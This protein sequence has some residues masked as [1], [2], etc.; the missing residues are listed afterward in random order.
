MNIVRRRNTCN[1]K[2]Y[3]VLGCYANELLIFI[4]ADYTTYEFMGD[5]HDCYKQKA[6][7]DDFCTYHTHHLRR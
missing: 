7:M 5:K 1:M 2:R 4:E 6:V 3:T